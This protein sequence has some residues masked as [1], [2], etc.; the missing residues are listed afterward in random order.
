M[1]RGLRVW[2]RTIIGA[3]AVLLMMAVAGCADAEPNA[4]GEPAVPTSAQVATPTPSVAAP[5]SPAPTDVE[6]VYASTRRPL[7]WDQGE[8]D[9]LW[10]DLDA[11][12]P[13]I[14]RLLRG[15]AG[16][17]PVEIVEMDEERIW[18]SYASLVINLRFRNGAT[19]SVRQMIRCDL[20]S[21][22]RKTNCLPVPD[23]WE[24]L[25]RNEVVVSTALT[26]W[27]QRVREYMPSVEHY[28]LPDQIRLGEPFA[29]SGAGYHEGDRVELSIEFIDQSKL[30][31]GE[32]PL[33]HGAFRWDGEFPKTAPTGYAIVS[34]RVFEGMEEV[35]GLSVSATVARSTVAG[36]A[37]SS[38]TPADAEYSE[39][40]LTR[41]YERLVDVRKVPG[42]AWT[43]LNE[44]TNRIEIGV[45]P[46]RGAREEWEAALATLDVP[47]EAI[48]I[49]V[50]CEGISPWPLDLGEPPGEAFLRTIDY[51]LEVVSQAPYG[52]T[53]QME[54]TLRN[55]SDG[56]VNFVLGGRPPYDFVVS[57]A[58]GGQVWHWKCAKITLLP[59]DSKTLEPGEELEF[60]GEWEQV[61]NRGEPVPPGTYLVRGVLNLDPP[62]KLVTEAHEVTVQM[63]TTADSPSPTATPTPVPMPTPERDRLE[64]PP[65]GPGVEIGTGYPYALYVHCGIRDAR[66]D[67]RLWMADPMLSDGSG[68]LPPDW[69]AD[70]SR[71]TMELVRDDLA[72]FTAESG[73]IVEFIPWPL[74][75]E[76][77]PCA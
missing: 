50:G 52:E 44:A 4:T 77:R 54:L 45:Y 56:T 38:L 19:W 1:K 70:D 36:A 23:H 29:I 69:T 73:R 30:P 15:I 8:Y 14:D 10:G 59:L 11:D 33:D 71:G 53:V 60:V 62:E 72:V 55:V 67:G 2:P 66:F 41:W 12:A 24:L 48:V 61:D 75:V 25:H 21:E 27:F 16:G 31:L 7:P 28:A 26:K 74:D 6:V 20:T 32:A 22:G 49:D 40:D 57:T 68:N 47:R 63:P 3:L 34:M 35:G 43:D 42:V 46:L 17:T 39:A 37:T 58:D 64:G 76:W 51:S 65:Q 13:I 5:P 18:T 9:P